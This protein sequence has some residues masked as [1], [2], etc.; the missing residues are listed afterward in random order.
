[1]KNVWTGDKFS[2]NIFASVDSKTTM[3]T[4][5]ISKFSDYSHALSDGVAYVAMNERWLWW[6]NGNDM[7]GSGDPSHTRKEKTAAEFRTQ[8]RNRTH[9]NTK[10]ECVLPLDCMFIYK[11][12]GGCIASKPSLFRRSYGKM[13]SA[14]ASW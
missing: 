5:E 3:F 7:E 13:I 6:L 2:C 12:G 11:S 4:Y 8:N 10:Q 14:R 9:L 1:M